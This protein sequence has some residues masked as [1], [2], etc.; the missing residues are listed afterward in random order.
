MTG[1]TPARVGSLQ[2]APICLGGN[3]FGWTADRRDSFA[4]LDAVAEAALSWGVPVLVDTADV[5]SA[6]VSGN[7]GGESERLIGD[8]RADRPADLV[9][10]LLVATKVGKHPDRRGL[11][12]ATVRAAVEASRARLR[13]DSI[14][15]YY[16]H[17]DDPS[18][19]PAQLVDTFADL[20][21]AGLI[22]Q[23]GLSNVDPARTR[24][25]VEAAAAL[26][27]PGPVAL[28]PHYSLVHRVDVDGPDGLGAVAT[29]LGLAMLPYYALASGFLTGRYGHGDR[30]AVPAGARGARVAA[31][32]TDAGLGVLD[33]VTE[34]AAQAGVAPASVAVAW[35]R[36]R[37]QVAAPIASASRVE[38]VPALLAGA[39]LSL[40]AGQVRRLDTASAPFVAGSGR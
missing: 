35:L 27:G 37:A 16:A 40:T 8:W 19:T 13:A 28:Q 30:G 36:T 9:A 32:L 12:P 3:V 29:D 2:I 24:S 33:V 26:G 1:P 21:H 5:Y 31:Y 39:G 34:V 11:A 38:Q 25:I 22:R 18:R 4:V 10:T 14:D 20:Q 23:W 7:R 6:W 17:E 15:L